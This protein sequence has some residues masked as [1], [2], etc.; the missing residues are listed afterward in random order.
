MA[1]NSRYSSFLVNHDVRTWRSPICLHRKRQQGSPSSRLN[2]NITDLAETLSKLTLESAGLHTRQNSCSSLVHAYV[3]PGQRQAPHPGAATRAS[4][5]EE[6]VDARHL[7]TSLDLWAT[8][9]AEE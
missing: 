6:S 3:P 2:V 4:S 9:H 8:A 5:A 7:Q 1:V